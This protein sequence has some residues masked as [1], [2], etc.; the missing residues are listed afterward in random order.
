MG[1]WPR[2]SP[3]WRLAMA[4]KVLVLLISALVLRVAMKTLV[5]LA[6][7]V[8]ALPHTL[9]ALAYAPPTHLRSSCAFQC[10]CVRSWCSWR[11][12]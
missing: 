11:C 2:S 6:S 8:R 5:A 9:F 12:L 7:K 3:G 1:H 4:L 10:S